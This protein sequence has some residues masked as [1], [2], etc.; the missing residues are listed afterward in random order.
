[1]LL[2]IITDTAC[3]PP[4]KREDGNYNTATEELANL[5]TL[6]L[7]SYEADSVILK[8]EVADSLFHKGKRLVQISSSTLLQTLL[9]AIEKQKVAGAIQYCN[10]RAI[11]L[12]DSLS[13]A[14]K[15]VFKRAALLV[16]NPKDAPD[17]QEKEVLQTYLYQAQ[18]VRILRP[19]LK[20]REKDTIAYYHPILITMPQCLSCHGRVGENI[21]VED[22]QLIKSLYPNDRAIGYNKGDLRGIWSIK[23]YN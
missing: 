4:P 9:Q 19:I 13:R 5:P 23:F 1:M 17:A 14:H 8:K 12:I 2:L 11:P 15:A 22:Y 16:R 7:E 20:K 10:V 3:S 6:D 21:N 18:K